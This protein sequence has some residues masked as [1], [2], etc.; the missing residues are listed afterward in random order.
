M[1]R[2]KQLFSLAVP[3]HDRSS[4]RPRQGEA[5]EEMEEPTEFGENP[6]GL[7]SCL[8]GRSS[9]LDRRPKARVKNVADVRGREPRAT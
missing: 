3:R 1:D 4:A 6:L 9:S 5:N 8:R 2:R 7:I